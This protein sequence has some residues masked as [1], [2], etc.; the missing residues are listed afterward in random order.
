LVQTRVGAFKVQ[1]SLI[2]LMQYVGEVVD[3]SG[4]E[5][6]FGLMPV[7]EF[8]RNVNDNGESPKSLMLTGISSGK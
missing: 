3:V 6:P 2:D 5:M 7:D 4:H 8:S 1:Q